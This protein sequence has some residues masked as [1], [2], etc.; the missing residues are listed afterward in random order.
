M[1]P[2]VSVPY[3]QQPTKYL[4]PEP[5]EPSLNA[6]F[7]FSGGKKILRPKMYKIHITM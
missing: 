5:E 3:S 7:L 1:E 4:H 2:E 6:P